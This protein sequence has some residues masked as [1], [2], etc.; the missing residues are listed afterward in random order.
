VATYTVDLKGIGGDFTNAVNLTVTG[1][2]SG[3]TGSFSP[4][5]VTPGVNGG[6]STLSIQTPSQLSLAQPHPLHHGPRSPWLAALLV[7]P[8]LGLRK[9]LRK[10]RVVSCLL[11]LIATLTPTLLLSGCGGGYFA[12]T[13]QTYTV[14]VTGSSGST[15]HSTTVTLTVQ[16][17]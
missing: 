7:I 6:S 9:R 17:Q 14:T 13:S 11:L 10:L 8:L 1:L 2:P 4:A 5:S 15:Q 3:F 16:Q 12:I